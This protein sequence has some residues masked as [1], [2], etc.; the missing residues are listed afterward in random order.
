MAAALVLVERVLSQNI[1][2]NSMS[3][4]RDLTQLDQ[5]GRVLPKESN[6]EPRL[7]WLWSFSASVCKE[8]LS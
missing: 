6:I 4:F 2:Q 3:A 8:R 5:F 7:C 1:Y